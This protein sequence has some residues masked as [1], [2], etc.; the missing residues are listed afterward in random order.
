MMNKPNAQ[1]AKPT[2][3]GHRVWKNNASNNSGGK[4]R[5]E[6]ENKGGVRQSSLSNKGMTAEEVA[7][8]RSKMAKEAV[9]KQ[10]TNEKIAQEKAAKQADL[11]KKKASRLRSQVAKKL[12]KV[13]ETKRIWEEA[14]KRA[15][16]AE[17]AAMG[18]TVEEFLERGPVKATTEDGEEGNSMDEE[19][20]GQHMHQLHGGTSRRYSESLPRKLWR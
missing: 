1:Y 11:D 15:T 18:I 5:G 2:V 7:A 17:T 14:E 9:A 3:P 4:G 20:G 16:E 8:N 10:A 6:G 19:G 12:E 13:N